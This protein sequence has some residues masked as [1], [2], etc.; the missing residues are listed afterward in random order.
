MAKMVMNEKTK[1]ASVACSC[2][3]MH[4]LRRRRLKAGAGHT[5][6]SST[7]ISDGEGGGDSNGLGDICRNHLEQRKPSLKVG[8]TLDCAE[9]NLREL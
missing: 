7:W 6:G 1:T 5:G 2:N 4:C 8:I 3:P 9:R